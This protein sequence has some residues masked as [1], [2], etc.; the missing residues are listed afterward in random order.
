MYLIVDLGKEYHE[1]SLPL[2]EEMASF[3]EFLFIFCLSENTS[4]RM[5]DK[6]GLCKKVDERLIDFLK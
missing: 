5:E 3:D 4:D 6:Y 2:F 1:M